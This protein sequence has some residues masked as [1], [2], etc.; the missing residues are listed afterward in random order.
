MTIRKL[1]EYWEN[2]E[3]NALKG[4]E[5]LCAN[6]ERTRKVMVPTY[7]PCPL[8]E[9]LDRISAEYGIDMIITQCGAKDKSTGTL[10]YVPREKL[11]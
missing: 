8:T 1:S 7:S 9:Q 3:L 5:C 4:K 2:F 11:K 10:M 6:C